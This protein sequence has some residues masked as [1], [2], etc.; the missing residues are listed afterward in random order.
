MLKDRFTD[1]EVLAEDFQEHVGRIA[2][3]LRP[4]VHM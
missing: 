4:F 3:V 2:A 1:E